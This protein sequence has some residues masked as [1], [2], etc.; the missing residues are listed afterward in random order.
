MTL[1]KTSILSATAQVIRII[2]GLII[3]KV[4]A[5]YSGPSGIAVVGQL[6]NFLNILLMIAG[7]F[8]KTATTK[9]TAEYVNE[10]N[11]KFQLWSLSIKLI[12]ISNLI[13]FILLFLLSFKNGVPF[14]FSC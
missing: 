1:I 4:I 10:D 14:F 7:D 13:L 8:M 6:Q 5:V 11:R 9:Y 3:T 12:V 2:S